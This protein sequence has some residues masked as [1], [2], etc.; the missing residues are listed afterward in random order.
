MNRLL[1]ATNNTLCDKHE[2]PIMRNR[3][4]PTFFRGWFI[5]VLCLAL[6][7]SGFVIAQIR[8]AQDSKTQPLHLEGITLNG[9][10]SFLTE[11]WVTVELTVTNP[12]AEG[13]EGRVVVFYAGRPDAQYAR[14]IW[15]PGR[16]TMSTW[17][18]VGPAPEKEAGVRGQE[19]GAR[20]Q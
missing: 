20:G 17:M 14:D 7:P 13:R 2:F 5:S 19:S 4:G 12:N 9:L 8:P 16:S 10:H 18:L 11:S 15:V 6:S 3:I 1:S